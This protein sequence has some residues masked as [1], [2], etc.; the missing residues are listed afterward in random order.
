MIEE[1]S[2]KDE[3]MKPMFRPNVHAKPFQPANQRSNSAPHTYSKLGK[4]KHNY[5]GRGKWAGHTSN[6]DTDETPDHQTGVDTSNLRVA[7]DSSQGAKPKK[8][9]YTGRFHAGYGNASE[10]QRYHK[11]TVLKQSRQRN[12]Q[13]LQESSHDVTREEFA[14]PSLDSVASAKPSKSD[15]ITALSKPVPKNVESHRGGK[16]CVIMFS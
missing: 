13:R 10:Q 16:K 7:A 12:T 4:V 5:Q 9:N 1:A 15:G 8:K 2:Q 6:K 11:E 14:V 3:E